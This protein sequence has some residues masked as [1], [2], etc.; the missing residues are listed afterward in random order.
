MKILI[1]NDDGYR[2]KGLHA[3]I[4]ALKD[5][6]QL[7][8]VVPAQE[9]SG[10]SNSVTFLVPLTAEKIYLPKDDLNIWMVEG[11]PG[12]CTVIALDQLM[13]EKPDLI[14]SGINNGLNVA[15]SVMYSGTVAAALQGAF[16]GIPTF[17]LSNDFN[18]SDFS[19]SANIF[20]ELLP[21]F[22]ENEKGNN[23]LY[24]INFPNLPL[25]EIK[26]MKKTVISHARMMER[27]EKRISPYGRDYYWH[28][29]D[30]VKEG[31]GGFTKAVKSQGEEPTD[32]E[33]VKA[34]YISITPIKLE[35]LDKEKLKTMADYSA[36][37]AKLKHR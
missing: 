9:K 21:N 10:T 18:C 12:D 11:T 3:L 4:N 15:D 37:F 36:A 8:V 27:F 5:E 32:L 6:H 24:N 13:E 16:Q 22:L 7:T 1:V 20:K 34:G 33:T 28:I 30:D 31:T 19:V 25:S 35:Y 29:Y 2:G 26:G 17:A 23:F 14:V